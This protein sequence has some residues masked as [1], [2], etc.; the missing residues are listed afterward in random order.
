[1]TTFC[2]SEDVGVN[3][4]NKKVKVMAQWGM[5]GNIPAGQNNEK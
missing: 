3:N 1:M 5:M 4:N 2:S